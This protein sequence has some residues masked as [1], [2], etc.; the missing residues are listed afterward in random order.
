ME[1]NDRLRNQSKK[2]IINILSQYVQA[3][4]QSEAAQKQIA[5]NIVRAL[6]SKK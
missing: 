2:K 4:L 5:E 1:K 3:N 6:F